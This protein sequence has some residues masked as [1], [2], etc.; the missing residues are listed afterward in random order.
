M[1]SLP[2]G[3]HAGRRFAPTALMFGNLITGCSVLAPAG[4]LIEL[5][6]DL[7]VTVS[8]AGLL[9]TFGAAVLCIGSPL[10]AW[11][12][13]WV[14]RRTLL[15]AALAVLAFTNAASALAPDYTTLLVIR[16]IMLAVGALYTPQAAGTAALIVSPEKRGST[17]AYVFLG[18]SLAAAIGLP[19]ITFV[20]SRYGW[21]AVYGGIG[22]VATL[23]FV[24]LAWRLPKGLLGARVDLKTWADVGR[25]RMILVLLL[26]TTLQM[27]G[28]FVVFTFMGP[29][30]AKLTHVSPDAVGLVFMLYGVSGLIGITIATR[31][32]DSWGPYKTSLLFTI[33]MLTGITVWALGAG[34]YEVMACAVVIWGLGF[35]STNS[36]QQVRLVAAA[37]SLASASV[38]LN[39]SVLYVGQALGSAIGGVLYARDLLYGSGY[40]A[41]AFV[42]L[43]LATL[44]T[45][46]NFSKPQS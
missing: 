40:V 2:D 21:R 4:M 37:P 26:I 23:G 19:L 8:T 35:A 28:Q 44:I 46:R 36:M 22:A 15:T 13:S 43:A 18:W 17:I 25:N 39:T 41:M 1:K 29:L 34:T 30:L 42:A 33:L 9:I 24:L 3:S 5:S 14:E 31:I 20:A 38:S 10:T 45:T 27:S 16:L 32:V 12:T 11:L 6:S 7:G